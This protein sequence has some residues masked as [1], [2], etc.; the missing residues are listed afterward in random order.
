MAS[1]KCPACGGACEFDYEK[2]QYVCHCCRNVYDGAENSQSV[3]DKLNIANAKRIEDYDF[4]GSLR[5]CDEILQE[6]PSNL[7]ANLCA[8]M[9]KYQIAYVKDKNGKFKATFM[10]PDIGSLKDSEYYRRLSAAEQAKADKIELSRLKV[11]AQSEKIPNYK[12]FISYKSD[13]VDEN[14]A[15]C[16]YDELSKNEEYEGKIFFA[17]TCLGAYGEDWEPHIYNALNSAQVLILLGSSV[18]NISSEWVA[19]EWKRFI[20][21]QN[22][23]KAKTVVAAINE[24]LNPYSLPSALQ[25]LQMERVL[26]A[27]YS[28]QDKSW[29]PAVVKKV[30]NAFKSFA[31]MEALEKKALSK[32][33]EKRFKQAKKMYARILETKPKYAEAHWGLLKCRIKAFDDYDIVVKCKGVG[34]EKFKEYNDAVNCA[35]DDLKAKY[36]AVNYACI[37]KVGKKYNDDRV[38]YKEYLAHSKAQRF[39]KKLAVV[40]AVL[41]VCVFGVYSYFGIT[42]PVSYTV[43]SGNAVLSGKSIYF[44]FVVKDLTVDTFGSKPVV[45]IGDGA[46]KNSNVQTVT[47]SQSV[48]EIGNFAFENCKNLKSLTIADCTYIGGGAFDGCENLTELTI[49]ISDETV[50]EAGALTNIGQD[51]VVCVPTVAEVIT[52]QLKIAYPSLQF[53]TYTRDKVEE[54]AYFINR[55]GAVSFDSGDDIRRAENSYNALT[56]GEKAQIS[57]YGVLQN[58]RA[59]FDAAVAINA[60]GQITLESENDIIAAENAYS[61]LTAEQKKAVSNYADLTTARAVFNTMSLINGIGDVQIN[62][63]PNIVAAEQAYLALS[64]EQRDLVANYSVLT[65]ARTNV[66]ILLAN[67]VIDKIKEIGSVITPESEAAITAAETAYASL[68]QEQKDRVSNY[69]ALIDSRAVY[70]AVKAIDNIGE[71]TPT[72]LSAITVAQSLYDSLTSAQKLKVLNYSELTDASAVYPVVSQINSI[73]SVMP[74]SLS[75]IESAE[76]AYANLSAMRQTKVSNYAVLTDSRTVYQTVVLI[77]NIGVVS[78][79]NG[80][81][82]ER[83][84]SSFNSLSQSQQDIVGNSAKLADAVKVYGVIVSIDSIGDVSLTSDST[85]SSVESSYNSLTSAQRQLVTN[86]DLLRSARAIYNLEVLIQNLGSLVLGSGTEYSYKVLTVDNMVSE[87]NNAAVRS[88]VDSVT[89]EGFNL[90]TLAENNAFADAFP[91]FDIVRYDV[92]KELSSRTFEIPSSC[93]S[94][95]LIGSH[96]YTYANSQIKFQSRFSDVKLELWN[97]NISSPSGKSA[98]D[99]SEVPTQYTVTVSFVGSCSVKGGAG[100]AGAR[101]SDFVPSNSK[102]TGTGGNGLQGQNGTPGLIGNTIKINVANSSIVYIIGGEGGIGG[103]GGNSDSYYKS[104]LKGRGKLGTGGQGGVGGQGG[105]GINV[106]SIEI[107]NNGSL[108]FIGGSGGQGGMGG[109]GA[110]DNGV[111]NHSDRIKGEEPDDGGDGGLGGVG[112]YGGYGIRTNYIRVTYKKIS[113]TGGDGGKGGTG[114][115]GGYGDTEKPT[116]PNGSWG[117]DGGDGGNGGNG[118]SSINIE[119]YNANLIPGKGGN[120]GDGGEKGKNIKNPNRKSSPGN[121]GQSGSDGAR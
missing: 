100:A 83:A 108:N 80:D 77:E 27:Q 104:G 1:M 9:A 115:A 84:Q 63:E 75:L 17:K 36:K 35:D 64:Y 30:E 49:G 45:K 25:N 24:K 110:D 47:L 92:S 113:I 48:R 98:I 31:D 74:S 21:Y 59:S 67:A 69:D 52:S 94:I 86:H 68:T 55:L 107:I 89:R 99:A 46:L 103:A 111:R 19:N 112:G 28:E 23:G 4:D 90:F 57:N 116:Y 76:T 37:E 101:G 81:K 42:Q 50:V 13:S 109:R 78:Q 120:G 34:L 18:T 66:D 73:G 14:Y 91:D 56:D 96:T 93:T 32:I 79:S 41:L 65:S 106:D 22:M 121:P 82:I 43:E 51:A 53:V 2:L 44:N 12:I 3:T 33:K 62:S 16:V 102:R 117:G 26:P 40:V 29:L 70:N 10:D 72:S 71:I 88:E 119:F 6:D 118:S 105:D 97:F 11:I 8:L 15:Q 5:L 58:A 38:N 7:S 54:C 85:I 87:L 39:F 114:G 60:I 95:G 61:A 20:A